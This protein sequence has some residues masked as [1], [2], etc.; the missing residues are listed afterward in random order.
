[1]RPRGSGGGGGGGYE[2][3]R[4]SSADYGADLW[5]MTHQSLGDGAYSAAPLATDILYVTP[6]VPGVGANIS[7]LGAYRIGASGGGARL[8]RIGLYAANGSGSLYP[9]TLVVDAGTF[10]T[11]VGGPFYTL[12]CSVV[13][14]PTVLYWF[15]WLL[16]HTGANPSFGGYDTDCGA[17]PLGYGPGTSV[18]RQGRLS[19]AQAYGALP[20][21]YPAGATADAIT[22]L[23]LG[24]VRIA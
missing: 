12:A 21:T 5:Y 9:G 18:N 10:G 22:F 4:G 23:P 17:T 8:C 7:A 20:A 11:G 6:Y 19:V 24:F 2:T 3:W 16:S 14:S 1:M 15:A 13:L